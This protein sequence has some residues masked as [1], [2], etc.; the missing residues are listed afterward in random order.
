MKEKTLHLM[1]LVLSVELVILVYI[2]NHFLSRPCIPSGHTVEI[3]KGLK[4]PNARIKLCQDAE[5]EIVKPIGFNKPNQKIF[6]EGYPTDNH[7]ALIR[8]SSPDISLAINAYNADG[9]SIK[10]IQVDG[11]RKKL[12]HLKSHGLIIMGGNV[13]QQEISYVKAFDSRSWTTLHI[14]WGNFYTHGDGSIRTHCSGIKVLNNEIGPSGETEEGQWSDGISVQCGD[15]LVKDNLITGVTDGGIVLFG[16]SGS[17][18]VNNRITA[19]SDP[20][21]LGI[22]MVDY[23]DYK[24]NYTDVIVANNII[25]AADGFISTGIAMGSR[26]WHCPLPAFHIL[27]YG[28]TVKDNLLMGDHFGYGLVVNGVKNWVVRGNKVT[29]KFSGKPSDTC[30]TE[31]APPGAFVIDN[32]NS[33]G[34]FQSEFVSGHL[35]KI[36]DLEVL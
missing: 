21:M 28:A 17:R 9:A 11:N 26:A 13:D 5:F 2:I 36:Y 22:G 29:A 25:V 6:T 18:I 24:G 34:E 15:T 14:N 4:K 23:Q 20:M 33:F 8:I 10:N 1:F 32:K 31:N 12:G 35:E 7:R 27:N 30:G 16:A 19:G 3:Y